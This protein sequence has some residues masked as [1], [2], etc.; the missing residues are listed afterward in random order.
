MKDPW[1]KA[2]DPE[3]IAGIQAIQ[4]SLASLST[5]YLA[6]LDPDG[7]P[8]TIPSNQAARCTEC[9]ARFPEAPCRPPFMQA[10]ADAVDHRITTTAQCPFGLRTCFSPL[11]TLG[12][13]SSAVAAILAVGRLPE[14]NRFS[15]GPASPKDGASQPPA[16]LA[17][18]HP[19]KAVTPCCRIFDLIFSLASHPGPR[20]AH[21][22]TPAAAPAATPPLSSREREVLDLVAQGLSNRAIAD[23]LFISEPTVKTH[24]HNI[25]KK[26]KINNRTSL[27][28]FFLQSM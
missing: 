2:F 26:V 10:I 5:L 8:L 16:G 7:A 14:S 1:P 25:S 15:D 27:A 28:L 11:G 9:L 22:G 20:G 19:E 3:T 21:A 13:A 18:T 12:K 24:I 23:R 17:V 6:V 4:D